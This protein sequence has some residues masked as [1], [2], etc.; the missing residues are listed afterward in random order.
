MPNACATVWCSDRVT[1]PCHGDP[2][3]A[4]RELLRQRGLAGKR[5]GIELNREGKA[6]VEECLAQGLVINCTQ[7][8]ILRIMPA[9]NVTL[10]QADKALN[11]LDRVLAEVSSNPAMVS[12]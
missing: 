7:G 6:V 10:K 4:T 2:I 9:L 12:S 1:Y 3:A 11:I 8:N 5:L